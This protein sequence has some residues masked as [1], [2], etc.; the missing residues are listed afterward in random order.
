[1]LGPNPIA[2]HSDLRQELSVCLCNSVHLGTSLWEPRRLY[3][4][5]GF[6]RIQHNELLQSSI[7]AP[8]SNRSSGA[9]IQLHLYRMPRALPR[10][11]HL[12]WPLTLSMFT[13]VT[14]RATYKAY[15]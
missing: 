11:V 8:L 1:M 4:F 5:F 6:S 13:G 15:L 7:S 14:A 10:L 9:G 12:L 3:L 2:S